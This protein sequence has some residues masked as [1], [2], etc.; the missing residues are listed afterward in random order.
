[1]GCDRLDWSTGR[2][3]AV[4]EDWSIILLVLACIALFVV[5]VAI[6]IVVYGD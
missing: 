5:I 3:Q 4:S 6:R 2:D 1:M